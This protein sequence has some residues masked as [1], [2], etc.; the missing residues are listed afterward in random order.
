MKFFVI[1]KDKS[2]R[3]PDKNFF[4]LGDKPLWMHLLDKLQDEQVFVDTDSTRILR[5]CRYAYQRLP[6]HINL[7]KDMMF[8]VSPVLLMINRFLDEHVEDENEVIITPHVTSPFIKLSTMKD[9]AKRL[10]EGYDSV[11]ACTSHKEFAYYQNKPI[12]FD[13]EVV[14]KTQDLEPIILGNGAFFIFTKKVFKQ[15][16]NRSGANPCFYQL[17]YK[18]AIE[19]DTPEDLETARRWIND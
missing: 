9:A 13:P 12:N 2:E 7:E 19:I 15:H 16:N 1:I 17:G 6:E 18:E 14:Q 11:Q 5:S 3:V 4:L 8:G 10:E